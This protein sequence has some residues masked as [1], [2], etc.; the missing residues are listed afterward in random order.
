MV[1]N[2]AKLNWHAPVAG[3]TNGSLTIPTP[4]P[5]PRLEEELAQGHGEGEGQSWAG[6][7]GEPVAYSLWSEGAPAL[8]ESVS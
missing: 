8:S 6:A 7:Q 4:T 5:M 2:T 1:K 3:I